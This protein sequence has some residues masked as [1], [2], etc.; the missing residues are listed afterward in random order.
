ME[1]HTY[2]IINANVCVLLL[3]CRW[4][5]EKLAESCDLIDGNGAA[6]HAHAVRVKASDLRYRS[7]W[8]SL[9]L[10]RHRSHLGALGVQP[11]RGLQKGRLT[12]CCYVGRTEVRAKGQR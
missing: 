10:G 1:T 6:L 11:M 8:G 7:E 2:I 9:D 5:V 3:L 12:P 4:R